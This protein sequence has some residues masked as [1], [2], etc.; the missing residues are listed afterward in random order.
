MQG[1]ARGRNLGVAYAQNKGGVGLAFRFYDKTFA[2]INCHL[3]S[4]LKGR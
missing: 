1:V 4:D 3:A 2:F